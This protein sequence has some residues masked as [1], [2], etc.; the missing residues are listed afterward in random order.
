MSSD[1]HRKSFTPELVQSFTA[2]AMVVR[3]QTITAIVSH[4]NWCKVSQQK[5]WSYSS[6]NHRKSFAPYLVPSFTE[7]VI[8]V[9]RQTITVVSHDLLSF[10]ANAHNNIFSNKHVVVGDKEYANFCRKITKDHRG[11]YR[12]FLI[13]E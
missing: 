4:Q 12:D 1:N 3:R 2:K 8:V 7:K 6:D 5:P 11:L 13:T 10:R 9:R